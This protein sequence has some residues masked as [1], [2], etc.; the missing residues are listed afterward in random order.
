M[1][2]LTGDENPTDRS[3][4]TSDDNQR[5][6]SAK[7]PSPEP[8]LESYSLREWMY[9]LQDDQGEPLVHA[10]YPSAADRKI[11]VL[12]EKSKSIQVLQLL[13][14]LIELSSQIFAEPALI[15]YFGPNKDLPLVHNHP[16]ATNE[17]SSYATTLASYATTHSPQ[18]APV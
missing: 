4:S 1:T 3:P 8:T 10:A 2:D 18:D 6:P 7:P 12:C 13:H 16:R 9:D 14:N 5:S 17:L 11:F 15:T